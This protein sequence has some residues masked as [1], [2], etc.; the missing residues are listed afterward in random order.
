M[1]RRTASTRAQVLT[2]L[3]RYSQREAADRI[4]VSTRT[5]RRW[6]NEGIEPRNPF[7]EL[8]LRDEYGRVAGSIKRRNLKTA[9]GAHPPDTDIPVYADR[10]EIVERD[11]RGEPTGQY[12][13]SDWVNYN[14][15]LLNDDDI[16]DFLER[17]RKRGKGQMVNIVFHIPA[18]RRYPGGPVVAKSQRGGT[19]PMSLYGRN[20]G[21]TVHAITKA[22]LRILWVGVVDS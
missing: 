4:G 17:L 16:V 10:K 21:E 13:D 12:T 19:G 20:I 9:P 7:V 5:I 18:G 1:A 2:V 3:Q 15:A 11:K 14:V 22:G 6:K 8:A